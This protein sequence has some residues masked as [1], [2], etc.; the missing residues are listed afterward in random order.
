MLIKNPALLFILVC[1]LFTGCSEKELEVETQVID[2]IS[3]I[4]NTETPLK[5]VIQLE[6]EKTREINP[7]DIE[8]ID[9]PYYFFIKEPSGGVVFYCPDKPEAQRFNAQNEYQGDFIRVGQGPGEFP[10]FQGFYLW[11][12]KGGYWGTGARKIAR[13]DFLGNFIDEKKIRKQPDI[14]IDENRFIS[15]IVEWKDKI[16]INR[17]CLMD[18]SIDGGLDPQVIFHTAENVNLIRHP[19]GQGGFSDQWG[20]PRLLYFYDQNKQRI[21]TALNSKYKIHIKDL[22]GN[23]LHVIERIFSNV[24]V[25]LSEKKELLSVFRNQS[26]W[27][28]KAYPSEL[29]AVKEINV[30]PD[31]YLSVQRISGLKEIEIDIF[32]PAG[33]YLYILIIPEDIS[34]E[35]AVFDKTGFATIREDDEGFRIYEEYKIK[36]LPEIFGN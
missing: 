20:T 2:G 23:T 3:H 19:S 21:I 28:L 34:L 7:Y 30:L 5:G 35:D 9:L 16:S 10:E 27:M 17:I 13:Y 36:N 31:G 14:L 25:G 1:V 22:A 15:R 26:P 8:E 32:D 6:V 11:W 24:K 33:R 18:A 4:M 29:V 12:F